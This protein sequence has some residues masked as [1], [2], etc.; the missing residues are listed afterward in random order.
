MVAQ[1]YWKSLIAEIEQWPDI[2]EESYISDW[3]D[4][5]KKLAQGIVDNPVERT[6]EEIIAAGVAFVMDTSFGGP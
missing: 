5:M 4:D 6:E 2:D 1:E 3:P